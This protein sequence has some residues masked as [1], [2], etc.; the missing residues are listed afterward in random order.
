MA[1]SWTLPRGMAIAHT[2]G[3][4]IYARSA[5]SKED[6]KCNVRLRLETREVVVPRIL[7]VA[8]VVC[9]QGRTPND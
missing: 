2:S 9:D 5:D 4:G 8:R 3:Q 6:V 1:M 7:F